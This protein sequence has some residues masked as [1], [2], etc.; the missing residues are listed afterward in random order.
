MTGTLMEDE[1]TPGVTHEESDKLQ[2][3]LINQ[4][5]TRWQWSKVSE[6][7]C[8]IDHMSH[9]NYNRRENYL[10]YS[11]KM[12]GGTRQSSNIKK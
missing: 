4:V 12:P 5:G 9:G 1:S 8:T 10:K 6:P 3:F 11:R 7:P 2:L